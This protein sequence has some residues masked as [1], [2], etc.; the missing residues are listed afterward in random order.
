MMID[1]PC[2]L[3]SNKN[4]LI[5]SLLVPF[6]LEDEEHSATSYLSKSSLPISLSTVYKTSTPQGIT[7]L[8]WAFEQGRPVDIDVQANIS[9]DAFESFEDFLTKAT[10]LPTLPPIILCSFIRDLRS[11]YR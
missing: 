9:D 2:R 7:S 6:R 4:D 3:D 10:E 1:V 5:L 11:C 8:K